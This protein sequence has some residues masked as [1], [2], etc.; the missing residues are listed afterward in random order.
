MSEPKLI[1][2]MLDGFLMGDSISDHGGVRSFP[3]MHGGTEEKY[4][5]K[6]ISVPANQTKLDALLLAGAFGDTQSASEYFRELAE[7]IAEEAATLQRLSRLE[8][9]EPFQDWQIVPMEG[10]EVGFDVYLLSDYRHTLERQALRQPMTH[11][12]AVNLGLDMC[13]ALAVCRRSGYLYVNLRPENIFVGNDKEYRIGDLGFIKLS[14]LEFASLPQRYLGCY[15]APEIADA[16]SALNSTLDVYSLGLILYQIYNGGT[17]PFEGRAPAEPLSAPAY[18]DGEMAQIILKAC[19]PNPEVRWQ[20]PLQMGQVLAT[21]LQSNIVN[22]TPI[23]VPPQPEMP[24]ELLEKSEEIPVESDPSTDEI[25]AEVDEALVSV[26]MTEEEIHAQQEI[27]EIAQEQ[28]VEPEETPQEIPEE[29]VSEESAS[30]ESPETSAQAPEGEITE[31]TDAMPEDEAQEEEASAQE[32]PSDLGVTKETSEIL[33]Q[34]ENLIAHELP[35]PVVVPEPIEVTLP[36]NA[37]ILAESMETP[38]ETVESEEPQADI[39]EQT[40][41]EEAPGEVPEELPEEIPEEVSHPKKKVKGWVI[42]LAV[43]ALLCGLAAG[44][45]AYRNYVYLQPVYEITL[46]GSED[47]L[48]VFLNTKIP[49][50]QLLVTCTDTY[51]HKFEAVVSESKAYFSG[52]NPDTSY[53]I[54]VHISE[55]H[56]LVGQTT[57]TYITAKQT[58]IIGLTPVTGAEEGSVIL[59]FTVQGPEVGG[60]TVFYSAIGEE[61]KSVSF[62]GHMVTL[63]GLTVGKAYTFRL[64]SQ[65]NLYLVG[66]DT[67]T[68]T[69][70]KPILAQNLQI[71]GYFDGALHITWTGSENNSDVRWNVRCYNNMGYDKTQ[72]TLQ[73][74]ISFE[75]LDLTKAYTVEVTAQGMSQGVRAYVSE[76]SVTVTDL[77]VTADRN[78]LTVTWNCEGTP[79]EGGW[80]LMYTLNDEEYQYVLQCPD[81]SPAVLPKLPGYRYNFTVQPA[82]GNTAFGGTLTYEVPAAESFSGYW[83]QASDMVFRMC[84]T[85]EIAQWEEYH[86]PAQDFKTTFAVGEKASFA[87]RLNHEYTTSAD[88]ITTLFVIRDSEGNLISSNSYSM[89]WTSMWY[90]GFGRA[91]IPAMPEVPGDYTVDIYFNG[92]SVT[93]QNFTITQ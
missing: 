56:K 23:V 14:S 80:L 59:S 63:N 1:S 41:T 52:L 36:E 11:L 58:S 55:F 76:N 44:A 89:T 66:T 19:D 45:F 6:V 57:E 51:G 37:E 21:Y 77:E 28:P 69:V 12:A 13:A 67:V 74:V 7:D 48:T 29:T 15:T 10:E 32:A 18:A 83:V 26:G 22:D 24:E 8:G 27:S 86:V 65:E 85:P 54:Q 33:A 61:E 35:T 4:I 78:Q 87:I 92:A 84:K 9:F 38:P 46:E 25:L 49:D 75:A 64:E 43:L 47:N 2:P 90:R 82:N 42:L 70:A 39:S 53:K 40:D 5:V 71:L 17:L 20:D 30:E 79:P 93:T 31:T 34:A 68:H 91:N 50:E 88:L 72:T 3:A 81:G 16:S 60:W 62:T 73:N